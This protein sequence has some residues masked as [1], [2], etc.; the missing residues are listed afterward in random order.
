KIPNEP[1]QRFPLDRYPAPTS[2]ALA[3]VL[4]EHQVGFVN[5]FISATY[6]TRSVLA[7]AVPEIDKGEVGAFLDGEAHVLARYLLFADEAKF[8]AGGIGGDAALKA[9]FLGRGHRSST[10]LSLRDFDLKT[11]IFKHRCSY[12]IHS[13]AFRGMPKELKD[14]VLLRLGQ[15]LDS[16]NPLPD[17]AYL[18]ASEKR[19]IRGILRDTLAGLPQ[20]W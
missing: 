4:L 13:A 14:R 15:A 20:G 6:R 12:M 3:H 8:P 11:R 2:D 18:P 19:A 5:R 9:H 10:G 7:G 17:Y 1:G 16:E